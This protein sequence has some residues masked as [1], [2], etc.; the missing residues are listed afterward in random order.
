MA[1]KGGLSVD[2]PV[3]ERWDL[4]LELIERG[5]RFVVLGDRVQLVRHVGWP[6]ADGLVHIA[7]LAG[8]G[9]APPHAIAQGQV[10]A[11][12][13]LISALAS[14]DRR[15]QLLLDPVSYTHL[16]AA[17]QACQSLLPGG[18]QAPPLSAQKLAAEV[19]WAQCMRAHGLPGFPD[20]NAQGAFDSSRF[21][22]SSPAFQTANKAC[23]ALE[24][25]GPI[26]AVPG[27]G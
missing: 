16:I 8:Q 19:K 2:E 7:V 21:D 14:E 18:G 25:T 17:D 22:H 12:R 20:P 1:V 11:A 23:K 6:G 27:N 3:G 15:F 13:G 10:D 26:S 5:E 4:A 9:R 24:P